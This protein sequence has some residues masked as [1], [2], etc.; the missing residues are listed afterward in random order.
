[1]LLLTFA[2]F[3]TVARCSFH[4]INVCPPDL[5]SLR[6]LLLLCAVRAHTRSKLSGSSNCTNCIQGC[7]MLVPHVIV[8]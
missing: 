2:S 7:H 8:Y 3:G 6:F 4:Q 5:R 1:M